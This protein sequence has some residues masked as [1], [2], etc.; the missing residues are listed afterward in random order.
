VFGSFLACHCYVLGLLL[1]STIALTKSCALMTDVAKI[2][3]DVIWTYVY[4]QIP[5]RTLLIP[6]FEK[7]DCM[8]A[9]GRVTQEAVTEGLGGIFNADLQPET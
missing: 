8:D 9:G 1:F 3:P 6:P 7:G 5:S 4:K 2:K